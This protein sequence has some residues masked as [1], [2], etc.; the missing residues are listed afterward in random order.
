MFDS[1]C[2]S[3]K[4]DSDCRAVSDGSEGNRANLCLL[5]AVAESRIV[6]TIACGVTASEGHLRAMAVL[7]DW[8]GTEVAAALLHEAENDLRQNNC[9]VVR[10]DATEPLKRAI[11][12]Y[13]K[14]GFV[15]SG[16][17]PDFFG[18]R[19]YEYSKRL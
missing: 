9:T 7:P 8:H 11:R 2:E 13:E 17:V 15:A 5:V 4:A 1:R 3:T 12:F 14:L 10:L 16:K 6:G 18:M 19:L